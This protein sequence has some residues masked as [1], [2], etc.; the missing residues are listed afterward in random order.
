MADEAILAQAHRLGTR[1][2]H[3]SDW[4]AEHML[5]VVTKMSTTRHASGRTVEAMSIHQAVI[6]LRDHLADPNVQQALVA[7]WSTTTPQITYRQL[8]GQSE[9]EKRTLPPSKE[10][11]PWSFRYEV[12]HRE[13]GRI[14]VVRRQPCGSDWYIEGGSEAAYPSREAAAEALARQVKA[15]HQQLS[16]GKVVAMADARAVPATKTPRPPRPGTLKNPVLVSAVTPVLNGEAVGW[17][18]L[19]AAGES[20]EV[21]LPAPLPAERVQQTMARRP[22]ARHKSKLTFVFDPAKVRVAVDDAVNMAIEEMVTPWYRVPWS[23]E[24]HLYRDCVDLAVG[25]LVPVEGVGR[26]NPFDIEVCEDC[27]GRWLYEHRLVWLGAGEDWD[28]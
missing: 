9:E 10:G 28:D 24:V 1:L 5:E 25:R 7:G 27:R 16:P 4:T 19:D 13:H 6:D 15:P 26:L 23:D 17:E 8:P 3:P 18:L 11:G 14:G 22:G 2:G 12:A 20:L 21:V